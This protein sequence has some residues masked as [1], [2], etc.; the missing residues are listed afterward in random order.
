MLY[1]TTICMAN[2]S[3]MTDDDDYV[4]ERGEDVL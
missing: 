4:D 2:G 3:V 1:S